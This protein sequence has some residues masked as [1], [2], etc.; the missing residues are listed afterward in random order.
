MKEADVKE[1]RMLRMAPRE[2]IVGQARRPEDI[3]LIQSNEL[4][5]T[6]QLADQLEFAARALEYDTKNLMQI[7]AALKRIDDRLIR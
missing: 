6:V 5:E 4:V 7:R 3:W 2:N 1:F